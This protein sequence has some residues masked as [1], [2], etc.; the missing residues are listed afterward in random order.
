MSIRYRCLLLD[1]DDTAVNS[2]ASVHYPAH[3]ESLRVLRP[4]R[5]T[6]TLEDWILTNFHGIME[7]LKGELGLS[8]E[9]LEVEYE[10]W[11]KYS[12][13]RTPEFFPGFLSV[14]AEYRGSGGKVAVV[15]HS[16]AD[17]IESH[18]RH[19]GVPAA[20]PDLIFGWSKDADKRKPSP[21]PVREALA[22]FGARP[23]EALIVDDLKPGVLM[24]RATGVPVAGA[25]WGYD[26]PEIERYM[27]ANTIA[28]FKSLEEFKNFL[29]IPGKA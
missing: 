2:A 8:E 3:L 13:S 6:P 17:V 29:F 20:V 7:Y 4:G 19:A 15:S 9:E 10:I 14:I 21:W 23:E 1:H 25:G 26:I 12:T 22:A 11:R 24:S 18:Y 28:Y 16:E 27:R 5:A